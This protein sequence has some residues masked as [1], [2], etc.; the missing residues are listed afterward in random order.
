M[1]G[2]QQIDGGSGMS[3]SENKARALKSPKQREEPAEVAEKH[4][5]FRQLGVKSQHLEN[6][7][8]LL[9]L[10]MRYSDHP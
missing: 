7:G 9:Q 4:Q 6:H 1:D 3:A 8:Q 10:E 2:T 5:D